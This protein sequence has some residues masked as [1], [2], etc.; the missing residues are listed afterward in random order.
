VQDQDT[1]NLATNNDN[2]LQFT[3][4]D[5]LDRKH[6]VSFG[7]TFDLPF[8][9]R[10]SV[11]GHFYSP[12]PQN[13]EMPE[14]TSGGEIFASDWLGSG[15]GSGAAPEPV[16]GT[17][18]G[19]FMR[20]TDATTLHNVIS[21]YNTH[22]AGT[23]TPAGHCLVGD[24]QCPGSGPVNVMSAADMSSLGWVMP[25]IASVSPG[26]QNF[27]WLK[28]FDLKAAWPIK[29]G[30]RVTVEPSASIFNVF[31]FENAFMA[32]NLPLASLLPGGPTGT[33]APNSVGGVTGGSLMP[34]RSSFQSG[35]FALDAPRQIQF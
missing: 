19:Q 34:F 27:T 21:Q 4:P 2:P 16:P 9:T 3:G 29:V 32:G 25:Q 5:A 10:L 7:G 30:E 23:L 15:L 28:T 12:L 11:M 17:N 1:I 31:N 18:I 35:T 33:L 8:W 13:L 14:L 20:G 26:A 24:G 22:L 6:Q